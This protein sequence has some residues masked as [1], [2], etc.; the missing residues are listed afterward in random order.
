MDLLSDLQVAIE[1]RS[2]PTGGWAS[3]KGRGAGIET[4]CHALMALAGDQGSARQNAIDVLS[5]TQNLM[6]VG[7]HSKAM[8]LR[9][10]GQQRSP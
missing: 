5:R 4:T 1:K 10:A 7:P 9:D 8:I 6:E 2:L 3:G